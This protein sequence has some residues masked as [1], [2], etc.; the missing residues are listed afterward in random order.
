M[1]E[2]RER[3]RKDLLGTALLD[4][5][6]K[7]IGIYTRCPSCGMT[8]LQHTNQGTKF[9][10][11]RNWHVGGISKYQCGKCRA[12]FK[13]LEIM[14]PDGMEPMELYD[15]IS[16]GL[17]SS[18]RAVESNEPLTLDE[19]RSMDAE[20]VWIEDEFTKFRGWEL[21]ENASDYFDDRPEEEYGKAWRAYRR[22][23]VEREAEGNA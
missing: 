3:L 11:F 8:D 23:P 9:S 4:K 2:K 22:K 17:E 18:F 12:Y 21:S 15:R 1:E 7:P 16:Q 5:E 6:G 13:T 10:H 20:P 14:V 19:L